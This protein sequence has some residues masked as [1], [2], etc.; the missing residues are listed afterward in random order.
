MK[1]ILFLFGGV[2]SEYAVS[3]ESAQAVLTHLDQ[4]KF[5]PLM[6]GI[7]KD[8][9]WLHYTGAVDAI[10]ADRWQN[11]DCVPCTLVLH[12]GARQ[13]LLLDGTGATRSFD[14]AFPVMHGKN[15]EDGTLQGL[16]ELAGVPWPWTRIAPTSWP[17]VPGW[18]FPGAWCFPGAPRPTIGTQR[19]KNWAIPSLSSP[20]GQAPPSASPG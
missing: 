4:S 16:L 9:R 6:V 13:L 17:P 8:G 12:R 15:G 18:T 19:R 3:L 7:T 20:F 1:T 5:R 14:A 2:S 10:G 11:A